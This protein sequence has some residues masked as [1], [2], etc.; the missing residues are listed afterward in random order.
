MI[1]RIGSS[2][3][4]QEIEMLQGKKLVNFDVQEVVEVKDG[5][6][7]I[8]YTYEQLRLQEDA[9]QE[10]IAR[11]TLVRQQEVALQYLADTDWY[12][13]RFTENGKAI[14]SEVLASREAARSIL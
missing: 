12:T 1:R 6:E 7:T 2:V 13:S 8:S 11:Y 14:P 9:T 3:K 10:D 4:P 5:V